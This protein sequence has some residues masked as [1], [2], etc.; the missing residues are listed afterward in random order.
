V[1][2]LET[3]TIFPVCM[4]SLHN[5]KNTF[6][7]LSMSVFFL[8]KLDVSRI[9]VTCNIINDLQSIRNWVAENDV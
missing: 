4:F 9:F 1:L 7:H 2:S 6:I 8:E 3:K 5:N